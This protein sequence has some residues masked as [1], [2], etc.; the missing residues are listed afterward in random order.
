MSKWR[1]QTLPGSAASGTLVCDDT[2][3]QSAGAKLIRLVPAIRFPCVS[4]AS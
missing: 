4:P 1:S 3:V 2:L